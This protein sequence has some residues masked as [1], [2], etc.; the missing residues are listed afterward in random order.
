MML[1]KTQSIYPLC[2]LGTYRSL[3]FLEYDVCPVKALYQ[4]RR[5]SLASAVWSVSYKQV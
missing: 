5:Q 1:K 2:P 4:V 3:L